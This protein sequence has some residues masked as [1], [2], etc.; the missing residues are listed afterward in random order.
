MNRAKLFI[1]FLLCFGQLFAQKEYHFYSDQPEQYRPKPV[2]NEFSYS[3][4]QIDAKL[5]VNL[6]VDL[7]KKTLNS[8]R[9]VTFTATT[10]QKGAELNLQVVTDS[11][12]QYDGKYYSFKI[13][14]ETGAIDTA[15]IKIANQNP[16]LIGKTDFAINF[17][18]DHKSDHIVYLFDTNLEP[19]ITNVLQVG[20]V[21]VPRSA[22]RDV[23]MR[24]YDYES[25]KPGPLSLGHELLPAQ[26]KTLRSEVSFYVEQAGFYEFASDSSFAHSRSI[27]VVGNAF[28]KINTAKELL[29]PLVYLADSGGYIQMLKADVPKKALDGFWLAFANNNKSLAKK[30]I[31]LYYQRVYEANE[32]FNAQTLGWKSHKGM[33]YILLGKPENVEAKGTLEVWHYPGNVDIRF[34]KNGL[35]IYEFENYKVLNTYFVAAVENI[36]KGNID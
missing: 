29:K 7:G 23:Y 20:Q 34:S 32:K 15:T 9:K 14:V 8:S 24:Y 26:K 19:I 4:A 35:G 30:L 36:K 12:Y 28:P 1:W 6:K 5:Y 33:T 31:R 27:A 13:P 2:F 3:V 10:I 18:A 11:Y 21:V 16:E 25:Q 17:V 22:G